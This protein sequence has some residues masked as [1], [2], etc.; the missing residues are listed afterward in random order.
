MNTVNLLVKFQ[1]LT[2]YIFQNQEFSSNKII[3]HVEEDGQ[4]VEGVQSIINDLSMIL[5][6]DIDKAN[7]EIPIGAEKIYLERLE[8][9]EKHG[10]SIERDLTFND[11]RQLR[12]GAIMLLGG[13]P[14]QDEDRY[15]PFNWDRKQWNKMMSKPYRDR[16]IIAGALIAAEYDRS[17]EEE[18]ID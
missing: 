1:K 6:L 4:S 18:K 17:L 5:D 14:N 7:V 3:D 16:L 9:I 11:F 10:I 8:Q 13:Y 2:N 12:E 15:L